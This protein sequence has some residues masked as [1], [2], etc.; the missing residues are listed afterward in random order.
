M[1]NDEQGK[2]IL[3]DIQIQGWH[4]TEEGELKMLQMVYDRYVS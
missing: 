4:K 2:E 3:K 1:E